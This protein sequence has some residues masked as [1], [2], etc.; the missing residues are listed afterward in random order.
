[1]KLQFIRHAAIWLEYAGMRL[2][3]DPM[4]S[5]QGANPPIVNSG[6]DRRNPLVPL[7]GDAA[8]WSRPDAVLVT[9]LHQDHWDEAAAALLQKELPVLCQP[10]DEGRLAQAGF[11]KVLPVESRLK[12][13]SVTVTRTSGRHGTGDIG[14]LMG[15]VS[16]FVL[17]AQ[18]EPTVY[19]AGDTIFCEEV[20][21]ALDTFKPDVAVIN[22][23]EARFAAG[24]PITMDAADAASVCRCAPD[25][26]VVAVHME[27]INHC[28]LTRSG[29]RQSL[30]AEGLLHRVR[31][32]QDGEWLEFQPAGR[33]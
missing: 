27:A 29:L 12:W 1:M 31:I 2:L 32:P 9:H 20:A 3:L 19:V 15:P 5:G 4:L 23:G 7:P 16:G 14:R 8:L 21:W 6:D 25:I 11:L 33:A 22:A 24:E 28:R 13:G 10:G 17:Q 30:E 18:D 26:T